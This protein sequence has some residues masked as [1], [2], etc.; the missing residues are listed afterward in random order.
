MNMHVCMYVGYVFIYLYMNSCYMHNCMYTLL[1]LLA[2][3]F[4][5]RIRSTS[6]TTA[7]LCI[8]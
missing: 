5:R 7:I 4:K 2:K 1:L 6:Y 3:K 8:Y